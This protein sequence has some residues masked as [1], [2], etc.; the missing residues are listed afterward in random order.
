MGEASRRRATDFSWD[1]AALDYVEIFRQLT[2]V[3]SLGET[4]LSVQAKNKI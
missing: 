1:S 3:S 2:A 4:H